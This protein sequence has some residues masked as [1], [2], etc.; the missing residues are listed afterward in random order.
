MRAVYR[1]RLLGVREHSC[2]LSGT[3]APSP[4]WRAL[5]L[6]RT[7]CLSPEKALPTAPSNLVDPTY[8]VTTWQSRPREQTG[9]AQRQTVLVNRPG[10]CWSL[11]S[12]PKFSQLYHLCHKLLGMCHYRHRKFQIPVPSTGSNLEGNGVWWQEE[13]DTSCTVRKSGSSPEPSLGPSSHLWDKGLETTL[14][15]GSLLKAPSS[16]LYT[17]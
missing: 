13:G 17:F 9:L 4:H 10:G 12:G 8:S 15:K 6:L 11:H 7:C 5:L 14:S 16:W 3:A 1:H 2:Q